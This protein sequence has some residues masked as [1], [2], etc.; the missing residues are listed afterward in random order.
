MKK[1]KNLKNTIN[2]N[3]IEKFERIEEK[4]YLSIEKSKIKSISYGVEKGR[5]VRVIQNGKVGFAAGSYEFEKLEKLALELTKISGEKLDRFPE[6]NKFEFP[7]IYDK[8]IED[9]NEMNLK[10]IGESIIESLRKGVISTATVEV[11]RTLTKIENPH[12]SEEYEET[13]IFAF[14]EVVRSEEKTGSAYNYY[15][16]RKLDVLDEI[17]EM[18][19]EAE[20]LAKAPVKEVSGEVAVVLS[21][22]AFNQLLNYALYPAFS[23]ENV[24][25]GRSP[26]KL[27]IDLDWNFKLIDDPLIDWGLCSRPFDDEGFSSNKKVLYSEGVK[28]FLSDWRFSRITNEKAGNAVRR[29]ITSYPMIAPSNVVLKA[30]IGDVEG[31]YVHSLTGAHTANPVSGDFSVECSNAIYK[32]KP[33]KVMLYGNVYDVLKKLECQTKPVQIDSTFCGKVMFSEGAFKLS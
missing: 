19:K 8:K 9:F 26:L 11:E 22:I 1:L 27:E 20:E 25:K 3:E 15:Q 14:V 5:A 32:D 24:V 10:S 29:E 2:E 30:K 23:V 12:V 28:S 16:S 13:T 18:V 17:E 33:V 21:P 4:W 6:C 7:K 31:L